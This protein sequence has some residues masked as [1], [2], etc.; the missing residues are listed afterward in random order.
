MFPSPFML[1]LPTPRRAGGCAWCSAALTWWVAARLLGCCAGQAGWAGAGAGGRP[2]TTQPLLPPAFFWLFLLQ[3]LITFLAIL[4]PFFGYILG[5]CSHHPA[6]L[7]QPGQLAEANTSPLLPCAA[8]F[9][10]AVGFWPATV[11]FPISVTNSALQ[12]GGSGTAA[13]RRRW[14]QLGRRTLP[15]FRKVPYTAWR[16]AAASLTRLASW[17]GNT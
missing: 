12:G 3:A 13:A 6:C 1:P 14:E 17:L 11:Y 16:H 7:P 4:M 8:G 10:G 9:I 15:S 2:S 5:E